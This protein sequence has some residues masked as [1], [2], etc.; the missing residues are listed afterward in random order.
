MSSNTGNYYKEN[1]D[2]KEVSMYIF[3]SARML[4]IIM[5]SFDWPT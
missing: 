2:I 5:I 4:Y 3:A 1:P